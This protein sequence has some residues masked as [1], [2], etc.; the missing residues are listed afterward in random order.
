MRVFIGSDY[1]L[2]GCWQ[3]DDGYLDN[4]SQELTFSLGPC[5]IYATYVQGLLG[6]YKP[7]F[8]RSIHLDAKLWT[9]TCL[10]RTGQE[11]TLAHV[12]GDGVSVKEAPEKQLVMR[13]VAKTLKVSERDLPKKI[14][15]ETRGLH[16]SPEAELAA[17]EVVRA[18]FLFCCATHLLLLAMLIL[19]HCPR[20]RKETT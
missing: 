11:K 2:R 19:S 6:D 12:L 17:S 5:K 20:R 7:P 4:C 10:H 16:L 13:L 3:V 8:F 14:V 15:A 18:L 1:L 9:L